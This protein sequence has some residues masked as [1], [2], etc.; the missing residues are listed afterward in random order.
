MCV[1]VCVC[2]YI[3]QNNFTPLPTP[4]HRKLRG[5]F[6]NLTSYYILIN[7]ASKDLTEHEKS[8]EFTLSETI[9]TK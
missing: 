3:Y 5:E 6:Q 2:V 8:S 7:F 4:P 9:N 1:C